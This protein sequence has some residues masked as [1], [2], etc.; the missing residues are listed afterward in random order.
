MCGEDSFYCVGVG[1]DMTA[2]NKTGRK[3]IGAVVS[4]GILFG[5]SFSLCLFYACRKENR[6]VGEEQH[7][8]AAV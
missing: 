1:N 6:K 7:A 4:S 2:V 8:R 3:N 5:I